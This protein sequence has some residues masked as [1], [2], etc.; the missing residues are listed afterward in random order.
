VLGHLRSAFEEGTSHFD[1]TSIA[2]HSVFRSLR[3]QS[4]AEAMRDQWGF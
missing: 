1:P 2:F 4:N 3:M